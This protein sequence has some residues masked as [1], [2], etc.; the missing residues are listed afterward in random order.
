MKQN[1][2]LF[3]DDEI[4]ILGAIRRAVMDEEFVA[5]FASSGEE[6]L[7]IME[8]K[9]IAVLV[10]DMR[11]PGMDGLLLLKIIKERYP[12]TIKIVLS[13]YTHI[14]QILAT[15]NQ[16]EIYQF[17][18]KPWVE[19][20]LLTA[21]RQGLE[22]YNLKIER[23]EFK[24]NLEKKNKAYQK[25]LKLMDEKMTVAKADFKLLKKLNQISFEYVLKHNEERE[26]IA[27]MRKVHQSF[28][29]LVPTGYGVFTLESVVNE[30]KKFADQIE[31]GKLMFQ[32]APGDGEWY[33]NSKLIDW[34]MRLLVHQILTM[35]VEASA[36]C[37]IGVVEKDSKKKCF[38][39]I[40]IKM[41]KEAEMKVLLLDEAFDRILFLVG[42]LNE[43]TDDG[44]IAVAT[45][46]LPKGAYG[47]TIE[48]A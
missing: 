23:M 41:K 38:V 18:T 3:V 21:V 24:T 9:E 1:F 14:G 17:I 32:C 12:D 33:G 2:V 44:S 5:L 43:V 39:R 25:V 28:L 7:K 4:H 37:I 34:V 42:I 30:V 40:D 35:Q 8:E 22:Y 27:Y 16:G 45:E 29:G 47:I 11:M 13:G 48:F 15:I 26:K 6:A 31:A 10:T 19:A 36:R 46:E 20:D